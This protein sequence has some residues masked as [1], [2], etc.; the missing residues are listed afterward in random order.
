MEECTYWGMPLL[1]T[2]ALRR[3]WLLGKHDRNNIV[4]AGMDSRNQ[5]INHLLGL[6]SRCEPIPQT[7]AGT[8]LMAVLGAGPDVG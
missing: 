7:V 2:L 4:S 1:P 8:S 3:L 5:V 6:L